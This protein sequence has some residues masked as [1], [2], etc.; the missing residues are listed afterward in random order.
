M[1]F[2]PFSHA[3]GLDIGD[4]SI[5]LVQMIKTG[6]GHKTAYRLAAWN[7]LDIPEGII[8]F[9]EVLD[10]DKA[11]N[12][13]SQLI[14]SSRHGVRG[15]ACVAC[16]PEVK[17]FIK[18][19][20]V[21]KNAGEG[22]IT[23]EVRRE[24]EQ[25]VP[26]PPED[27]YYDWKEV[28]PRIV[29]APER[30]QRK[31]RKGK[32]DQTRDAVKPTAAESG[33]APATETLEAPPAPVPDSKTTRI[34]IGAAPR[35]IIDSYTLMLERAGVAPLA[36]EIEATAI[37]RAIVPDSAG[38]DAAIGILDI[39][40]ARSALIIWDNGAIQMSI[41]IPISGIAITKLVSESLSVSMDDAETLKR[42]CGLD[43]NRCEDKMWKILYPL[44]DDITEKIR[45]AL[46]FYKIGFPD[47]KK[48]ETLYL[49]GGGA[50]FREI[51][52]VLS[53]KL[54]IKVLRGKPLV[55]VNPR[56][57]KAFPQDLAI[58]YATAIGLAL[59]AA[60]ELERYR[61]A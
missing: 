18:I 39:G 36:L 38:R 5:K 33:E 59:R 53:R 1:R 4:R 37:S 13:I 26:L 35:T 43:V 16:L 55:N 44:I 47:G 2:N 41:G 7:K 12:S 25:N 49:C 34:I 40:A 31:G 45:N 27:I 58:N 46:R 11:A 15:R 22:E 30:E 6:R 56:L 51:D 57:P 29:P 60:D 21:G 32:A 3:F 8:E 54:A 23:K 52:L 50:Q 28:G 10:I 48:I 17:S 24:L 14:S 42:E 9:G 61:S 19:I 20:E